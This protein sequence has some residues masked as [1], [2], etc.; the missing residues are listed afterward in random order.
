MSKDKMNQHVWLGALT[1]GVLGTLTT[2]LSLNKKKVQ[3]KNGMGDLFNKK[4]MLGGVAGG[5]IGAAAALLLAPK[6]G[7]ELLKEISKP[8]SHFLKQT[9][10]PVKKTGAKVKNGKR[11]PAKKKSAAQHEVAH[12][13]KAS[14]RSKPKK[15]NVSHAHAE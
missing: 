4:M 9:P 1:A 11:M 14:R 3:P 10:A 8:L 7:A 5:V 6:S 13:K 12:P 2:L 15:V